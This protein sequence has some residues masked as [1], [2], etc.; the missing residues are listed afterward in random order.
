MCNQKLLKLSFYIICINIVFCHS[1]EKNDMKPLPGSTLSLEKVLSCPYILLGKAIEVPFSVPTAP[2]QETFQV[3][4]TIT[5]ALKSSLKGEV[6][7][8]VNVRTFPV[9]VAEQS[10]QVGAQYIFFVKEVSKDSLQ[11]V[12]MI[13]ATPETVECIKMLIK[14]FNKKGND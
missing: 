3:T 9:K 5:D 10:P 6:I 13:S 7:L 1:G 14:T 8:Y 11:I 2:G 12:R 4:I